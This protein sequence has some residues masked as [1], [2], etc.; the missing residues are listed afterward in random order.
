[1]NE[2]LQRGIA[3]ARSGRRA[4]ARSALMQAVDIDERNELAWLW[5]SGVVDEPDDIRVCL[6]NVLAINPEN[7]QARQGLEWL[8]A[9]YGI[10]AAQELP[11]EIQPMLPSEVPDPEPEPE[12]E[13]VPEPAL[14]IAEPQR[15]LTPSTGEPDL[16]CPYCG[17]PTTIGQRNCLRCRHSL[18]IRGQPRPARSLWLTLLAFL[19]YIFVPLAVVVAAFPLAASVASG[20]IAFSNDPTAATEPASESPLMLVLRI[21]VGLVAAGA[22]FWVGRGLLRRERVAYI[23]AAAL[24]GLMLLAGGFLLAQGEAGRVT[25]A[26]AIILAILAGALAGL[27]FGDFVGTESRFQASFGRA[28]HASGSWPCRA[29][30]ST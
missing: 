20:L 25:G 26:A 5:L 15:P 21:A 14:R 7:R 3:L 4:E 29:R 2:Q 1:M 6:E 18:M 12:P 9:R 16:P 24:A 13:P 17:A 22:A 19:F 11:D 30:H 27:S 8:N 10:P 23:A 28:D